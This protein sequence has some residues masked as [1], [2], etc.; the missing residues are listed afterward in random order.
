MSRSEW[1]WRLLDAEDRPVEEATTP[2]FTSR[3]DAEAW[4][5]ESWRALAG[6]G[7]ATAELTEQGDPV[8][9]PLPLHG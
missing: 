2:V 1:S 7:A 6:R 4:L 3:F 9:P 8:G 5:G